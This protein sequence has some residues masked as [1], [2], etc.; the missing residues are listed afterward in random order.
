MDAFSTQYMP[1]N[2]GLARAMPAMR[3]ALRLNDR[4]VSLAM[5]ATTFGIFF[6][7]GLGGGLLQLIWPKHPPLLPFGIG[8]MIVG[9]VVLFVILPW[10]RARWGR[11]MDQ[12]LPPTLTR[13]AVDADG[14]TISD[15][16]SHGHWNWAHL[17]GAATT[18]DGVVLLMGYSGL[19]VP[20]AAF[21]NAAEQ[22]SFVELVN[23]RSDRSSIWA[24]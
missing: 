1:S 5:F 18:P 7:I 4:M 11:R 8:L 14:V 3:R 24:V 15:D 17:R 23:R 2:T 13:L 10:S 21:S 12:L 6:F 20:S 19:F 16:L 22:A 9:L